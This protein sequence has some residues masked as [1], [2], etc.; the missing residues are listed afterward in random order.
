M[1]GS[2]CSLSLTLPLSLSAVDLHRPRRGP[3]RVPLAAA[4]LLRGQVRRI[5]V[6]ML[7]VSV[8]RGWLNGNVLP[9][10]RGGGKVEDGGA[11]RRRGREE[12]GGE[13]RKQERSNSEVF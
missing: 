13:G 9:E 1:S 8:G 2:V 5:E 3:D 11:R 10:G 4:F 7:Q 6:R 12:G